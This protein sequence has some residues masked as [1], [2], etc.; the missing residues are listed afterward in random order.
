MGEQAPEG[1]NGGAS[2]ARLAASLF[3]AGAPLF[4]QASLG[5]L[6]GGVVPS[7][8][9][10]EPFPSFTEPLKCTREDSRPLR[11]KRPRTLEWLPGH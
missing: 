1:Q 3:D 10:R 5:F 6:S 9:L 7:G 8:L 4:A 2:A 11:P